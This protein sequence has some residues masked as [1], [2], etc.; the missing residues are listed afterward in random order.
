MAVLWWWFNGSPTTFNVDTIEHTTKYEFQRQA[1]VANPSPDIVSFP[2]VS[3]WLIE[4]AYHCVA[5]Q[6]SG[7][8]IR[9]KR[10]YDKSKHSKLV[11]AVKRYTA[12]AVESAQYRMAFSK[13]TPIRALHFF[14]ATTHYD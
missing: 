1:S 10:Q 7:A 12:A 8:Y 2:D 4:L 5:Q 13:M 3:N 9:D 11:D 6:I 14:T